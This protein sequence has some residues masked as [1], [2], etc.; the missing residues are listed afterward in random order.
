M[1][2]AS[3]SLKI[4]HAIL[5]LGD[6]AAH[7]RQRVPVVKQEMESLLDAAQISGRV[8]SS[9]FTPYI[10]LDNR[11]SGAARR[12]ESHGIIGKSQPFWRGLNLCRLSVPLTPERMLLLK[13]KL[14]L[15]G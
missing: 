8:P 7:L 6:I 5:Q 11:V 15:R 12:L 14:G 10:F 1:L 9:A 3:L 2:V 13:Q 4:G